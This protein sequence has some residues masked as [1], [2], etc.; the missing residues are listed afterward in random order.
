MKRSGDHTFVDVRGICLLASLGALLLV[1]GC[2]GLLA[3]ILL[4]GGSLLGWSLCSGGLLLS[5]TLWRHIDCFEG[6]LD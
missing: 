2:G 5:G 1:T 4:L 3:S 6:K